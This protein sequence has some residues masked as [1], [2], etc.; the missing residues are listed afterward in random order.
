[1]TCRCLQPDHGENSK[2]GGLCATAPPVILCANLS[3]DRCP[4]R[5]ES[6]VLKI[7]QHG[8]RLRTNGIMRRRIRKQKRC[9]LDLIL[10]HFKVKSTSTDEKNIVQND[11]VVLKLWGL[12]EVDLFCYTALQENYVPAFYR[13]TKQNSGSSAL[14]CQERDM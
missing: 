2:A 3:A 14:L 11:F 10:W 9:L 6:R 5:V 7:T 8:E 1:M 4:M 13:V 12:S